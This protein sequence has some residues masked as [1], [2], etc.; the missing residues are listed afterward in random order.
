MILDIRAMANLSHAWRGLPSLQSRESSRLFF[1]CLRFFA[2]PNHLSCD[3]VPSAPSPPLLSSAQTLFPHNLYPPPH[4]PNAGQAFV[5]IDRYLDAAR[6]GP[7]YLG[8]EAI[9]GFVQASIHYGAQQ[10]NYYDLHAYVI[11]ANHVHLLVLPRVAPSRFLKTL[12]GYITQRRAGYA[13]G[14]LSVLQ[15]RDES[16]NS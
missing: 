15:S 8:Q 2:K 13:R 16:P 3:G 12:K 9:A 11:M 10:L 6:N 7:L 1:R 14:G 4:K 5:W